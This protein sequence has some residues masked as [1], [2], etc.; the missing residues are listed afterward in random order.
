MNNKSKHFI[1]AQSTF[2]VSMA[3]DLHNALDII[4]QSTSLVPV[5]SVSLVLMVSKPY[6]D[7]IVSYYLSFYDL[8][9]MRE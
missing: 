2:P 5:V 6:T 8:Q 1:I 3:S 4:V 7:M 9:L